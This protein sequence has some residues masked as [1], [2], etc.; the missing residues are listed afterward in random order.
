MKLSEA[1]TRIGGNATTTKTAS[2]QPTTQAA[3]PTGGAEDRLRQALK[4]ATAPEATKT[5]SAPS[6]IEDMTKIAAD[7]S[8]AEHEALVKEAQLYGAAVCDGFMA[9]AAQYQEAAAKVAGAATPAPIAPQAKI[10]SDSTET[11]EKFAAEN[12]DL[13]KEAMALGYNT[14]LGQL[15]K[16]GEDAYAKGWNDTMAHVH[17]VACDAFVAGFK[18]GRALVE[19]ATR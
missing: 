3:A 4:E 2:T 15:E 7:L 19:A 8:K 10:A 11:F 5:A 1:M 16:L 12:P 17:K 6:P 14:T 18:N 9:R 13:V